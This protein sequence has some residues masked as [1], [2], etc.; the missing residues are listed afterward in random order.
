MNRSR[1]HAQPLRELIDDDLP[2][3]ELE[4]LEQVDALLRVAVME[5]CEVTVQS[6]EPGRAENGVRPSL[7]LIGPPS[8]ATGLRPSRGD[9][10]THQLKLTFAELALVYKSLQAARTLGPGPAQKELLDHTI[11][12]VDQALKGRV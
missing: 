10:Q 1:V 7:R 11:Q 3:E 9:R 2:A 8:A 5:A 12:L 6:G 4:R